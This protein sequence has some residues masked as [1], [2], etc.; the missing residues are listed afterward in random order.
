[1]SYF[2]D[3]AKLYAEYRPD[4]PVEPFGPEVLPVGAGGQQQQAGQ[5]EARHGT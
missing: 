2:R 1:M 3:Q 4:Y 5:G